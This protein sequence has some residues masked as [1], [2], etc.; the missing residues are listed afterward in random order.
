VSR[1]ELLTQRQRMANALG[2]FLVK[3]QNRPTLYCPSCRQ[4]FPTD[5][6]QPPY[7]CIHKYMD[8]ETVVHLHPLT[9]EELPA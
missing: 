4:H 6:A 9:R 3:K 5:D 2:H 8:D 1:I 7:S